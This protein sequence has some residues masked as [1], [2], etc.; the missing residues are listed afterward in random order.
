MLLA[1][2]GFGGLTQTGPS[3]LIPEAEQQTPLE[4]FR[5]ELKEGFYHLLLNTGTWWTLYRF[6]LPE[7][8]PIDYAIGNY[9]LSTHPTSQSGLPAHLAK[10]ESRFSIRDCRSNG[11]V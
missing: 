11:V 6:D 5:I 8:F 10:G 1:D 2:V 4:M 9:F 7:Q 3:Q